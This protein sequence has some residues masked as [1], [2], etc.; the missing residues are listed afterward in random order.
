M[1]KLKLQINITIDGFI[2]RPNGHGD[3]MWIAG[4]DEAGFN[5]VIELAESSDTILMGRKMTSQ[6]IDY[7]EGVADNHP[8]SPELPLAQLMVN[9]RKIV[10][11]RTQTAIKGRN[12]EVENGDL[13]TAVQ[14]LKKQ[15]GKDILV[16]GG[17]DFVSSLISENLIDEYYLIVNPVAIG[18]GLPIFKDQKILKLDSIIIFKNGKV[19]NKYLPG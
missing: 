6:F 18:K 5:K 17:A 16:Y 7:W 3:W 4:R 1:R 12:V 14:A 19:L 8:E 11:S 9:L 13:V 15:P 10:F 2:A